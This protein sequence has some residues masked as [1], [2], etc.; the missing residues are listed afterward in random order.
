[1]RNLTSLLFGL[2]LMGC[3]SFPTVATADSIDTIL[4]LLAQAGV[5]DSAIID[6][7]PLVECLVKKSPA[8]CIDVKSLASKKSAQLK[9]EATSQAEQAA[10]Q[11]VPNDPAIKAA[12][13]IIKAANASDWIR[14]LELTGVK[15]L[16][17]IACKAGLSW[18]G[19]LKPFVCGELADKVLNKAE[20]IVYEILVTVKSWPK[21]NIWK[22]IQ[23]FGFELACEIAPNIPMKSQAC[24]TLGKAVAEVAKF[25]KE[26]V[27]VAQDATKAVNKV[28]SGG[29]G[30][31][32]M[33]ADT[34]YARVIRPLIYKRVVQ[35][36]MTKRSNLGLDPPEI[37]QCVAYGSLSFGALCPSKMSQQLH[38]EASALVTL[39]Q[40]LP[41]TYFRG[42][43]KSPVMNRAVEVFS[44][45]EA[46]AY[47]KFI[48]SL[49]PQDWNALVQGQLPLQMFVNSQ[50][51]ADFY[52]KQFSECSTH[53]GNLIYGK[54][55]SRLTFPKMS[56]P[57]AV[58]WV[59]FRAVGKLFSAVAVNERKRLQTNVIPKLA[60]NKCMQTTKGT[61]LSFDC[62]SYDGF[63]AC[64]GE[65]DKDYRTN[66]YCQLNRPASAKALGQN[67][68]AVLGVKRCRYLEKDPKKPGGFDPQVACTRPWKTKTCEALLDGF[69]RHHLLPADRVE[70]R[71]AYYE[72]PNFV[73]GKKTAKKFVLALNGKPTE[74][75]STASQTNPCFQIWDP[76]GISCVGK[77]AV[78]S[79]PGYGRVKFNAC[80]QD[81][82]RNGA[83]EV[84]YVPDRT[85][86]QSDQ[87]VAGN[88][89][90]AAPNEALGGKPL[91]AH[92]GGDREKKIRSHRTVNKSDQSKGGTNMKAVPSG[93]LTGQPPSQEKTGEACG[94]DLTYL[95]P[96]PPVLESSVPLL[97]TGD[98]FQ[99][100]CRYVPKTDRM[101]WNPCG[102]KGMKAMSLIVKM[103][104][105]SLRGTG[106]IAIDGQTVGVSTPKDNKGFEQTKLWTYKKPGTHEVACKIDNPK[107]FFKKLPPQNHFFKQSVTH[108]VSAKDGKQI[109]PFD[110]SKSRVLA[111]EPVP[112]ANQKSGSGRLAIP[113]RQSTPEAILEVKPKN[114]NGR[115]GSTVNESDSAQE[116]SRQKPLT[117]RRALPKIQR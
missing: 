101:E 9:K 28:L 104:P 61:A 2:L 105:K 92:R 51:G 5:I 35:A 102:K 97:R 82:D 14:V 1:M 65:S 21:V 3:L 93:V 100:R 6:A 17:Q 77:M 45:D 111:T 113:Q 36:L 7:K 72:K 25:G 59:C 41:E 89:M 53:V 79:V 13:D 10:Q 106:V 26:F 58:E 42:W 112:G 73:S 80:P 46:G 4:K 18:G 38:K 49:P 64:L 54:G 34:Y 91:A 70:T 11:F 90:K 33:D 74:S 39:V 8:Q 107:R 87:K 60:K 19:P 23:L 37:K 71:C 48:D 109:T 78:P 30:K 66:K 116:E 15:L 24:G 108:N 117:G 44:H 20:P 47:K 43:L 85:V 22:L 98:Q 68:V 29:G 16:G 76:L 62:Q 84:C 103:K 56:P 31:K 63:A 86:K 57:S 32:K 83:D 114:S 27:N 110:A 69:P 88:S 95:A 55:T 67:F 40:S 75:K 94:F 81:P 99:I 12:V 52:K 96:Q 50:A 115:D